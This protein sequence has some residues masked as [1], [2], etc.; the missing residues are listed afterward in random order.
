DWIFSLELYY[1]YIFD[2]SYITNVVY[3]YNNKTAVSKYSFD[4]EGHIWGFDLLLQR[5]NGR[6]IDGWISYSFNYARYHDPGSMEAFTGAKFVDR[7]DNWYFPAF[8]RFSNLN[9]VLNFKPLRS[10]NIYTRFG[11]ASGVPRNKATGPAERVT[12]KQP[13]G[14]TVT[15]YK[16][17][18]IYSDTERG[19]AS[20]PLDI[21]FSWF[22][23]YPDNK[24]RTEVYAAVEN[25]LSL[26]Y[27]SKGN[28]VTN[29]YT[30]QEE[31]GSTT[32]TFE[33]PIPMVSFGFK[34]T[35]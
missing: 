30:G 31:E 12:V 6:I 13:N 7:S 10:F 29:P 25:A 19:S 11:F 8:H 15:K 9:L 21:K 32:A 17:N 20:L 2:N 33:L 3:D 4:G 24:V 28:T 23:F 16:Q 26:V 27:H 18:S 34:W 35:Y 22:F 5:I 14:T 1:K